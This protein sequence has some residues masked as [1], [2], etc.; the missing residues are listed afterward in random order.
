MKIDSSGQGDSFREFPIGGNP[1]VVRKPLRLIRCDSGTDSIVWMKGEKMNNTTDLS[2]KNIL[3]KHRTKSSKGSTETATLDKKLSTREIAGISMLAALAFVLQYIEISLP[4]MPFFITF[5]LS[6]LPALIGAF[7]YGPVAG[8]LIEFVKNLLHCL[9]SQ[10]A[11]VGELSNFIL[12]AVFCFTAGAVYKHKKT[13][14]NALIGGILGAFA[15]GIICIPSNYFVVYPFYYKAFMPE[16]VVLSAYQAILPGMKSVLQ[17]LFVFNLPFTTVKGLL[18]VVIT[19]LIYK[20][21][22][23]ILKGKH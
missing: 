19:M 7:A 4:V 3:K 11:T 8:V 22:S 16:E 10:S 20:S 9:V 23:P 17:S 6:D 21:I 12:G 13:K 18:C 15:M 2:E 5:D 1:L 14:R